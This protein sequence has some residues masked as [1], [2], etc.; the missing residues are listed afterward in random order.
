M[1]SILKVDQ[2][3]D[4]GGNALITSDG[5]GN[6]TTQKLLYPAWMV[7]L[8][9]DQASSDLIYTKVQFDTKLVDTDNMYDNTTNYRVTIPSGKAGKYYV[10]ANV[11]LNSGA[12]SNLNR[13]RAEIYKNGSMFSTK[14]FDARNNYTQ[15]NSSTNSCI[16]DLAVSDYIEIFGFIDTVSGA[17]GNF[18]GE[19]LSTGLETWFQ[20][21][22]IGD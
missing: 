15:Q 10:E 22:R 20:G 16:M 5:S 21:Y 14:F 3:Q 6:I 19:P 11:L 2:L 9:F 8:S 12:V 4:S 18:R 17:A 7:Y 13:N 1:T